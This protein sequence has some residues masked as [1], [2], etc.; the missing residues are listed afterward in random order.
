MC[1]GQALLKGQGD[2]DQID[3]MIQLLGTPKE[4]DWPG[5]KKLP[6]ASKINL[7]EVRCGIQQGV[8]YIHC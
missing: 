3:K 5:F 6:N 4:E 2:F 7:K 1:A 8:V